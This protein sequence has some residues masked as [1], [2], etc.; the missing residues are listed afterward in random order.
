MDW[1]EL[2]RGGPKF[3]GT[4][5]GFCV[6]FQVRANAGGRL[7]F[8]S[9]GRCTIRRGTEY[10]FD[11]VPDPEGGI[12]VIAGEIV[13]IQ[14]SH[15]PSGWTWGARI[16]ATSNPGQDLLKIH[17]PRVRERLEKPTGPPLKLFTDAR[18]PIRT[19]I[20]VYSMILNGYSP[21]AMM[22]FGDYQWKP[23][24]R[25]LLQQFFPFATVVSLAEIR[26]QV[27]RVGSPDLV[28]AGMSHWYLMKSCVSLL[29]G[30]AEFCMM[31]D[32]LFILES[33]AGPQALSGTHDLVF[34]PEVDNEKLYG[35]IWG[36]EFPQTPLTR[37][38]RINTALY[39]LRMRKDRR[40]TADAMVRGLGKLDQKW[41]WEQGFYAHLFAADAVHELPGEAFWYPYFRGLPGGMMGY[42]Y[43]NNPCGFS[44]VHFG[45]D[46]P[47]PVDSEALQL[48]P[49]ILGCLR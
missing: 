42:D 1:G 17:L 22:L 5:P 33:L 19:V 16:D 2:F 13:C 7:C 9:A 12:E 27:A 15:G 8:I 28:D 43:A 20:S 38:A 21:S 44:M 18:N 39:W 31:D 29:C 40:R 25:S 3:L 37:T 45:G 47:K 46:V 30:P 6:A 35:S 41:A 32:D 49:Q 24:A 34:V 23:F 4:M 48:M 11:G 10:A 36:D 14:V 26:D